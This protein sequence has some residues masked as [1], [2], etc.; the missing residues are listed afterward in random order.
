MKDRSAWKD[1]TEL[2]NEHEISLQATKTALRSTPNATILNARS[3][4]ALVGPARNGEQ[5]ANVMK[6][7]GSNAL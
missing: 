1:C 6:V 7:K 3:T 2:E 4:N 5:L